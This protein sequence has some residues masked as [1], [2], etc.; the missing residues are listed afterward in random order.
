MPYCDDCNTWH[1]DNEIC[2][3]LIS[4]SASGDSADAP[5][6]WATGAN[7]G[8]PACGHNT[9]LGMVHICPGRRDFSIKVLSPDEGETMET[10][11]EI[12]E[13]KPNESAGKLLGHATEEGARHARGNGLLVIDTRKPKFKSG[14]LP[15]G[16]EWTEDPEY[17][18]QEGDEVFENPKC[19]ET[20]GLNPPPGADLLHSGGGMVAI[21]RAGET[22]KTLRDGYSHFK[23]PRVLKTGKRPPRDINM[24]GGG[25]TSTPDAFEGWEQ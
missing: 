19:E 20:W 6:V 21:V 17:V 9:P 24:T 18:L 13:R 3:L 15:G 10:P 22:G 4:M 23:N 14:T 5:R 2:H 7:P 16:I 1:R 8:C 25:S 11:Y 12:R